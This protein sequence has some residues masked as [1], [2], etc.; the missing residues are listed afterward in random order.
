LHKIPA[1]ALWGVT[2]AALLCTSSCGDATGPGRS[3]VP[4]RLIL[5]APQYAA[6]I[7]VPGAEEII[8]STP[9]DW[10]YTGPPTRLEAVGVSG[11]GRRTVAESP[12]D[13]RIIGYRFLIQD[14]HVFFEV[15]PGPDRAALYRAPLHGSAVPELLV[16]SIPYGISVSPTGQ[17]V[18]WIDHTNV[19]TQLVTVDLASGDTR[20]YPLA[21][22]GDAIEAWEPTGRSVVV[23]VSGWMAAGTPFQWLDLET[24]QIDTW[25]APPAE[26]T[27]EST[28]HYAWESGRPFLYTSGTGAL[29]RYSIATGTSETIALAA[30]FAA[31]WSPDFGSV[32]LTT[33]E[34]LQL[35]SGP[36]GGDC[37]KWRNRADRLDTQTGRGT[38]LFRNEGPAPIHGQ[39]STNGEWLAFE[40]RSCGGGC[41]SEG[42]GVYV[43]SS[44]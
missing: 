8:Y 22:I 44:R 26:V 12:A 3:G 27:P 21:T 31:G 34:C 14:A 33:N 13:G 29:V 9:F 35:S 28:R 43:V 37:I 36:F 2:V 7:W 42:D 16:D 20:R 32:V 19:P 4:G 10:P 5:E 15:T 25:L 39:L 41:Y 17:R 24:G 11:A 38:T 18:A 6:W 1:A 23:A 40:Y 30:G